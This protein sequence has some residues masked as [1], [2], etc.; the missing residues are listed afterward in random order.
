MIAWP[1]NA[2]TATTP[3]R[4][5]APRSERSMHDNGALLVRIPLAKCDRGTM[6]LQD[7]ATEYMDL[8]GV[9]KSQ[10]VTIRAENC[11]CSFFVPISAIDL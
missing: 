8:A 4:R 2:L 9:R 6:V 5:T 1:H 10:A 7:F 3:S 11:G